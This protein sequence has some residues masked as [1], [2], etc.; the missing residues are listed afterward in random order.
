MQALSFFFRAQHQYTAVQSTPGQ[1]EPRLVQSA[2]KSTMIE[3]PVIA[4][5]TALFTSPGS[6]CTTACAVL[7]EPCVTGRGKSHCAANYKYIGGK[8]T[9]MSWQKC[10]CVCVCVCEGLFCVTAGLYSSR[11]EE[12]KSNW[13][14]FCNLLQLCIYAVTCWLISYCLMVVLVMHACCMFAGHRLYPT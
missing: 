13:Q 1:A 14:T 11:A 4:L 8:D 2:V 5:F 7:G 6:A 12:L 10:E 3:F 9:D